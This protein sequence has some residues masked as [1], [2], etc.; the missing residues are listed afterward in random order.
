MPRSVPNTAVDWRDA[1]DAGSTVDKELAGI[2]RT[3]A[4]RLL[5]SCR[6]AG[7]ALP[8]GTGA[9]VERSTSELRTAWEA[10]DQRGL[11]EPA[12]SISQV[13]TSL[14]ARHRAR[15]PAPTL[16]ALQE[17]EGYVVA[18]DQTEFTAHLVDITAGRTVADEEAQIPLSKVSDAD[19]ARMRP[20]S[21]FRWVIGYERDPTGQK[22]R[23]SPI[24]FRDLPVVTRADREAGD[25]WADKILAA[26]PEQK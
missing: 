13:V 8:Q 14:P 21:I 20:G 9:A 24:V 10:T 7:R 23:V 5:A 26:F 1:R 11:Q 6:S 3:V 17:W 16:H 18:I 2:F 15:R 4:K 25:A 12:Q 22:R 19:A